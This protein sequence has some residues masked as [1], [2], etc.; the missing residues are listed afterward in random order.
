MCMQYLPHGEMT[1]PEPAGVRGRAWEIACV[2]AA[3]HRGK[4]DE[5]K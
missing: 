5:G 1:I 3:A 2:A 4:M